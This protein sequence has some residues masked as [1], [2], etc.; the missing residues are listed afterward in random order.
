LNLDFLS[1]PAVILLGLT[2][3]LLLSTADW[4]LRI[5]LLGAQYVGVFILVSLSWPIEMAVAKLIAGWMAGA[6]LAMALAGL[7]QPGGGTT[8]SALA[9]ESHPS[10]WEAARLPRPLRFLPSTE[11]LFHLLAALL[12]GLTVLSVAPRVVEWAPAVQLTQ[13]W[14]GLVLAGMGLLQLG[15]TAR[16]LPTI[17]GLLTILSGFEILY[18]AVE[19]STLVAGLLAAIHLGL[20]LIGAYLLTAL[21]CFPRPGGAGAV[22]AAALG[23]QHYGCRHR[24]RAAAR[25]AGLAA[26][27]WQPH[28]ADPAPELPL[29]PAQR[30]AG[31]ARPPFH[32]DG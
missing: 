22:R 20:A 26:S 28:P 14:G 12:V 21:D 32:P 30:H 6:V 15:F 3:L 8:Q 11:R 1:I 25:P 23:A 16:P 29:A 24:R 10:D 27:N 7:G 9:P 31:C 13:V 2:S 4:R 17:L 5:G 19:N 18:A